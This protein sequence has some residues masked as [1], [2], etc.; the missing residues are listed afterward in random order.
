[1]KALHPKVQELK[2]RTAGEYH[3]F[4]YLQSTLPLPKKKVEPRYADNPRVVEGY[5]AVFGVKD[6]DKTVAVKGCFAKSIQERGPKSNAKNKILHLWM[7]NMFEPLGQYLELE[8]DDYGLRFAAEFDDTEGMPTR[9]LDQTRSGTINQYSFGFTYVWDKM[10]FDEKNEAILMYECDLFEGSSVSIRASN[11]ETYTIRTKEDF[12]NT[13]G[14]LNNETEDFI[15]S[16][17]RQYRMEI[18]QL[19]TRYKSLAEFKPSQEERPLSKTLDLSFK[20]TL[21]HT[22][23]YSKLMSNV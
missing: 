17:P 7:H 11:P 12:K 20:P 16:L 21:D 5:L 9:I 15:N 18:R 8:E 19:V 2:D 10:E 4:R 13:F 1:M 6:L 23:D 14:Q 3:T 22:V